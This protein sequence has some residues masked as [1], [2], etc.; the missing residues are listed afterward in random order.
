[1]KI[2][3]RPF[4]LKEKVSLLILSCIL[5]VLVYVGL[6]D[7]PV[8]NNIVQARNELDVLQIELETVVAK[9]QKYRNMEQELSKD[10]V[11]YMLSYNGSNL[12]MDELNKIFSKTEEYDIQFT[13]LTRSG[14]LVR[15][16]FYF[17]FKTND[18]SNANSILNQLIHCQ[19]RC[20]VKDISI[21][22]KDGVQ[23][24]ANAVFYETLVDGKVDAALPQDSKQEVGQDY[25]Q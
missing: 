16:N 20:L 2:L 10:D 3:S 12:E 7:Q 15:R 25:E 17:S 14:N 5:L 18:L 11:S 24:S 19:Y 23:V 13:D 22:Q 21:S 4:T 9:E 1:M 8:R 6:V